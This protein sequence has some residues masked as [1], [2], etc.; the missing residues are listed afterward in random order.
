MCLIALSRGLA[1]SSP[2]SFTKVFDIFSCTLPKVVWF[3]KFLLTRPRFCGNLSQ[4][5]NI[6]I[7]LLIRSVP[8]G[9]GSSPFWLFKSLHNRLARP[10]E[11][12]KAWPVCFVA[13]FL[14]PFQH[15]TLRTEWP[16]AWDTRRWT[17]R[18]E[19]ENAAGGGRKAMQR[20]RQ[21][22]S[23]GQ[24]EH[25]RWNGRLSTRCGRRNQCRQIVHIDLP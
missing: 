15:R 10:S 18:G 24:N 20:E 6:Y 22:T 5:F 25:M 8:A 4:Q 14:L 3:Q 21:F 7:F 17:R 16:S 13:A 9:L 23:C 12:A 2:L 11:K 19:P 1:P